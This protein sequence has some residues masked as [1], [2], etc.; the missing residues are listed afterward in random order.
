MYWGERLPLSQR[1]VLPQ[2]ALITFLAVVPVLNVLDV[3]KSL[4]L[5]LTLAAQFLGAA[6]V[7]IY[8]SASYGAGAQLG[9]SVINALGE[10]TA[11]TLLF[12]PVSRFN[13]M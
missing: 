6:C 8:Q 13:R 12:V 10:T 9:P 2:L 4:A 1:I 7:T 11:G 5:K 3:P